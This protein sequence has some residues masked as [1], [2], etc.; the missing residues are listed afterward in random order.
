MRERRDEHALD[1]TVP[2]KVLRLGDVIAGNATTFGG[3]IELMGDASEDRIAGD[4]IGTAM[5]GV[6]AIPNLFGIKLRFGAK[7]TLIGTTPTAST[8]PSSATSSAATT[9][10]AS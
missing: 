3:G 6:S 7:N 1:A 4:L 8:T 2:S 10:A 5:Y 9:P